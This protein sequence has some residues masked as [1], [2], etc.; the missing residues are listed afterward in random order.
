VELLGAVLVVLGY[1]AALPVIVRIRAVFAERRRRW[2][3]V[4]MAGMAAIVVGYLLGN[5]PL[6]AAINVAGAAGLALG[7]WRLGLRERGRE[8]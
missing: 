7:W 6:P 4:L 1:A 8:P 3:A 2:F 5:R